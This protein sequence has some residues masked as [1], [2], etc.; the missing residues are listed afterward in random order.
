MWEE[1]T[2][3]C[4]LDDLTFIAVFRNN[5]SRLV[6][7]HFFLYYVRTNFAF[8]F[9]VLLD[10][11]FHDATFA[12]FNWCCTVAIALAFAAEFVGSYGSSFAYSINS[13]PASYGSSAVE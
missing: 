9:D 2:W 13:I 7:D 1:T 8:T 10:R 5:N 6:N 4:L 12:K 11:H 3:L